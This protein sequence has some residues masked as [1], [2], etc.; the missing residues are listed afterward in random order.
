MHLGRRAIVGPYVAPDGN[1]DT[2]QDLNLALELSRADAYTSGL[3]VETGNPVEE[4]SEVDEELKRA[5]EL[6][7]IE[8]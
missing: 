5:L 7:L 6:S 2:A 1:S 3:P 4:D 8:H